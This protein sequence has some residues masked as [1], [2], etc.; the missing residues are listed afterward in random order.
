[1]NGTLGVW[2]SLFRTCVIWVGEAAGV[3]VLIHIIPG[4]NVASFGSALLF[5]GTI[6]L[7]NAVLWPLLSRLLFPL[8]MYTFGIGALLLNALAVWLASVLDAGVTVDGWAA[9]LLTP[10]GLAAIS[11][12]LSTLL[13]SDDDAWYYRNVLRRYLK[14]RGRYA[15]TD[16]PGVLFLEIDGL[17]EPVL[18]AAIEDGYMPTL[19]RWLEEGS[20]V[21]TPWET[22]LSSQTGASQAG[23]LHGNNENLPAFR[24][25]EKD[26]GNK[27]MVST[28]FSDAPLI[29]TRVSNGDGLLAVNGASRSNLFSGDAKDTIFTYSRLKDVRH[30]YQ[31]SW[32]YFYSN[33]RNFSRTIALFCWD[34][35]DEFLGRVRQRVLNVKPRL[36]KGLAYFLTRAGASVF[37]REVTTDTLVG[38]LIAGCVDVVYATYVAYDE[39]AHHNGITDKASMTAL[40]RIDKQFRRLEHALRFAT[41]P[42]HFVVLSDHGQSNGA[43]FKQRCGITLET[44]VRR[45]MGA[46][47]AVV[48][49][50]DSNQDHFGQAFADP[51]A[52]RGRRVKKSAKRIAEVRRKRR[53]K[54]TTKDADV[55]VLASGNLGL[56]YLTR[57][58][59]RLTYE[60][61][62]EAFPDLIPGLTTHEWVGFVMVRSAEHGPLA[63]GARGVYHLRD[64][65]AEGEN[66]LAHF[67]PHAAAHLRRTDRF[68]YA[69]DILVNSA[70][71]P[72]TGEVAAFEELVGSH[73]GLG[74]PQSQPFLLHPATWN[75]GHEEIVGAERLHDVLKA[76]IRTTGQKDRKGEAAVTQHST[77]S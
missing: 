11:V 44:L 35:I 76:Q 9:L 50:L 68:S 67:G 15:T 46:D 7:I 5:V 10:I 23:I 8:L 28:G 14:R 48:S 43:T 42:Y 63:I 74:G 65:R 64:D 33:P 31:K 72:E 3:L 18:R 32:Y 66:P 77:L 60:Q 49:E 2:R 37:L 55:I 29:E 45:L 25:V 34:I 27:V 62:N 57:W 1:M 52:R 30:F 21:I 53:E 70:Y 4:L 26:H 24:W 59:E 20:H 38:D 17:A 47:V 19:A 56:I 22:D 73:G 40:R 41:R 51:V 61:V 71:D 69:P 13:T 12:I 54:K 75:I 58:S 36:R 16:V 39:I 6:A